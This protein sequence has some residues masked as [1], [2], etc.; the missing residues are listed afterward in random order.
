MK[1]P[2]QEKHELVRA[3]PLSRTERALVGVDATVDIGILEDGQTAT[4]IISQELLIGPKERLQ[5]D[6]KPCLLPL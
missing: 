1:P 4:S 3:G 2:P 6:K 5:N